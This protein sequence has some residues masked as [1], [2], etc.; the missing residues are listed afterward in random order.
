M[1]FNLATEKGRTVLHN[2]AQTAHC[3]AQGKIGSGFD[4][5]AAVYGGCLYRRFS[6]AVLDAVPMPGQPGFGAKLEGVV[7]A[8]A[9]DT[10]IGKDQVTLPR[11]VAMRMCDVDCGSQTVGMV[12]AVNAWRAK[13]PKGSGELWADLQACNEELARVLADGSSR[14]GQ[15]PAALRKSRALVKKMGV[16]SGVPIEPD[17]QTELIDALGEVEGV[18][19]GVVPGA[20]GFDAVA[21]LVKDDKDTTRR[22]EAFVEEWSKKKEAKVKLLSVRGELEGVRTEELTEFDGWL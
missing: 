6:P 4:V 12:K 13:D 8:T 22:V 14:L 3:R 1:H 20:G 18:Y 17:S 7:R 11:G 16:E 2:L 9:W 15:L 5:A 10:E 21:V 19:G